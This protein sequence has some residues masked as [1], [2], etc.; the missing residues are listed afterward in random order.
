[1]AVIKITGLTTNQTDALKAAPL[2]DGFVIYADATTATLG[3]NAKDAGATV[4]TVMDKIREE[5]GGRDSV[6]R[7]LVAVRNKL[8]DGKNVKAMNGQN[9]SRE[10]PP[11]LAG[12]AVK[13]VNGD[14]PE[15]ES[16]VGQLVEK[17]KAKAKTVAETLPPP[18][19][20]D[21]ARV[22]A[23]IAERTKAKPANGLPLTPDMRDNFAYMARTAQTDAQAVYWERKLA[24]IP[25]GSN[26]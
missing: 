22:T 10:I 24:Q 5:K 16:K 2:P 8:A 26:A 19:P 6:Y 9:V 4:Q 1:M 18:R 23:E 17:G 21:E 12:V 11:A 15:W 3:A 7:S 25:E 20:I 14:R 13:D